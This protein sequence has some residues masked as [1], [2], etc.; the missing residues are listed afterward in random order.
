MDNNNLRLEK[1]EIK[2][3]WGIKNIKVTLSNINLFVGLNGTGKTTFINIIEAVSTCDCESLLRLNFKSCTLFFEN[4]TSITCSRF[5]EKS[6]SDI[7]KYKIVENGSVIF[8]DKFYGSMVIQRNYRIRKTRRLPTRFMYPFDISNEILSKLKKIINI[9]WISVERSYIIQDE[10][11]DLYEKNEGVNGKLREL[12][13]RIRFYQ[14]EIE[15]LEKESLESFR[16]KIFELMLYDE[17]LDDPSAFQVPQD[18]SWSKQLKKVFKDLGLQEIS[19]MS[20]LDKHVTKMQEVFKNSSSNDDTINKNIFMFTLFNRTQGIINY[21]KVAD[22]QR[23]KIRKNYE[24]YLGQIE[25]FLK[26]KITG[27]HSQINRDEKIFNFDEL[28]S[29]EKQILIL[30][31]EALLQKNDKSLFIADEPELSLHISWQREIINAIHSLNP[32]AQLIFATHS[33]EVVSLWKDYVI[34]MENITS[35]I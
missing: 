27:I 35:S 14:S 12:I 6:D 17:K 22:E 18:D 16:N 24:I 19:I 28:S 11:N 5:I 34:N 20:K 1:V 7:I 2:K 9:S 4:N 31:S 3:M 23:K 26:K 30:L 29:G 21:S 8:E 33:P 10:D 25:K 32:N 13:T 15:A